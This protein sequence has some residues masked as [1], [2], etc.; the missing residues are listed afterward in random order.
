MS[1]V[2]GEIIAAVNA[3]L[4]PYGETYSPTGQAEA[5]PSGYKSTFGACQYL[6]ISKSAL[7]KLVAEGRIHRIKLNKNA[8][9]GKVVFATAEL[10][11]YIASCRA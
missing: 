8:K 4:L 6:G 10:E 1:K 3:L 5:G 11:A 9:N 7:Y 2:P